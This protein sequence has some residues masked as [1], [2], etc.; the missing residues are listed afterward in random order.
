[1]MWA[2]DARRVDV[3]RLARDLH[4]KVVRGEELR[5]LESEIAERI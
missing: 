4:C 2:T 5:A 1:M 3:W